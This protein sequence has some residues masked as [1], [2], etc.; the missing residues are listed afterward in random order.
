MGFPLPDDP[1]DRMNGGSEGKIIEIQ[2]RYSG[3]WAHRP[4]PGSPLAHVLDKMKKPV[5]GAMPGNGLNIAPGSVV[6]LLAAL[7]VALALGACTK[8]DFPTW[9]PNRAAPQSCHGTPSPQ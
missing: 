8:C 7:T 6:R 4:A 5:S 3:N 9:Q 1:L 2:A